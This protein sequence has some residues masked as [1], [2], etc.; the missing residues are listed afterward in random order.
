MIRRRSKRIDTH[1]LNRETVEDLTNRILHAATRCPPRI[2][3]LREISRML[4]EFSGCEVVEMW[5]EENDIH[6]RC[7]AGRSPRRAFRFEMT[8]Y[9]QNEA[10]SQDHS[11]LER[12]CRNILQGHF[13]PSSPFF[14]KRGSFWT[15]DAGNPLPFTLET[16][17]Q[18]PVQRLCIGGNYPSLALIRITFGSD[19]I[20]L[21]QLKSE[22]RDYFSGDEIGSYER[23]AQTLGIALAHQKA[24]AALLE[25]VKELTCLYGIARLAARPDTPLEEIL[26]KIAELFPPAWQYPHIACAS[27]VLNGQTYSTPGF[28]KCRQKQK[29]DIIVSGEPRG[30]IE[31]AYTQ[32]TPDLDEGP[33][34]KEERSLI[35]AVAKQVALIIEQRQA[36]EDKSSLHDQLRHADRLATIGQLAAGVAHELNEPLSSILGFAQLVKKSS[37]LPKQAGEDI[38]KIVTSSL[39]A[40]EIIKKLM[41]FARQMPPRETQVKL[42]QVVE[43][44][45]YFLEARCAKAGIEVVRSLSPDLPE[46]TAD[47]AQI[48]QVLINL[49]VNSVQA[50]PEGGKLT[51]RTFSS[52]DHVA[53]IVED[54]G[55]GMSE[56]VKRQIFV[57]FFTTK[58]IDQGTGLGL[59]V[60]HGIVT[61]HKGSVKV[62]S[63]VGCG[64]RFEIQ[65]PM[66]APADSEESEENGQKGTHP[67]CR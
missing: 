8:S 60:V 24:E 37:G 1:P 5:V 47:P 42:N 54:T 20:G 44:G 19:N 63:T 36:E 12:F 29:A 7:E 4:I 67:R 40:R 66:T 56:D 28:Q 27:I 17:G 25:R 51:V 14:T 61:S 23:I 15:G 53:L 16:N 9:T 34:L 22:Q 41:L 57:P 6:S 49:V 43:E 31:V 50:M 52:E 45:L 13:D 39:H 65:L 48:N 10:D 26:Q 62:E 35:D 21:L 11:N 30:V 3:F 2:E 59:A 46:I 64:T 55:I 58:D 32:K 38:E 33:F 18:T